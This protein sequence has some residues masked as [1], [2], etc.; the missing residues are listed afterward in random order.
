MRVR[1]DL[2]DTV[3]KSIRGTIIAQYE[4]KHRFGLN[5]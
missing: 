5:N 4:A 3:P 1:M 2:F